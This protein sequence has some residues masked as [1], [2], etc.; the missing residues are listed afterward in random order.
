MRLLQIDSHGH[1]S[2]TKH[3]HDNIPAYAILS[4][5]WEKD[6]EE[7]VTFTDMV[8]GSGKNKRGYIQIKFCKEQAVRSGL[9]FFWVDTCCI[10]KSSDS[11]LTEAIKSMF[12]WYQRATDCCIYLSDVSKDDAVIPKLSQPWESAFRRSRWF[13]RGWTLQQLLAPLSVK[14]FSVEGK[15]LG[16]KMTMKKIIHE[17]TGISFRALEGRPLHRFTV[18]DRMSWAENRSTT[19]EED[20][21]YF[22]L[23]TFATP[24]TVIY[25]EGQQNAMTQLQREIELRVAHKDTQFDGTGP[26]DILVGIDETKPLSGPQRTLRRCRLSR[27]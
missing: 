24:M 20:K 15:L 21:V 19:R 4:H 18:K 23:G 9:R 6:E 13:T 26:P 3:L 7:E 22:L 12:R 11:E 2:I 14:F 10:N 5:T 8:K 17:I 25:G 27:R 16:D 1:L